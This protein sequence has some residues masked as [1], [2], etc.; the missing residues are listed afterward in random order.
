MD[1]TQCP[2][3]YHVGKMWALYYFIVILYDFI[4]IYMIFCDFCVIFSALGELNM[5]YQVSSEDKS[6]FLGWALKL[7]SNYHFPFWFGRLNSAYF[8][9]HWRGRICVTC[10]RCHV[11]RLFLLNHHHPHLSPPSTAFPPASMPPRGSRNPR[12]TTKQ[13][14]AGTRVANHTCPPPFFFLF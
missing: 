13:G 10:Q 2:G 8:G 5:S 11:T 3:E 7:I 9:N 6:F 14:E 1:V 12:L 4:L